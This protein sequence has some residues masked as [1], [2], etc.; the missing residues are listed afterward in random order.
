VGFLDAP[1]LLQTGRFD[2]GYGIDDAV[3]ASAHSR[4]WHI[5]VKPIAAPARGPA[6]IERAIDALAY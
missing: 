2:R 3:V 6:E 5:S 1:W 4:F